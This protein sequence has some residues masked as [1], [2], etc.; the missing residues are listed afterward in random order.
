MPTELDHALKRPLRVPQ[1]LRRVL[2]VEDDSAIRALLAD[3]LQD[4]GYAVAEAVDG[5]HALE[6]LQY[7]RPDLIVLD[8]MLPGMSGWQ[9]LDRSRRQLE[10][11][12]IPVV[13]LSAIKGGGDYPT[14][15]G[16]AAW[17]TKPLDV[18]RFLGAVQRLAGPPQAVPQIPS[19]SAPRAA[20]FP[21]QILIIEDEAP[22]QD[23]LTEQLECEGFAVEV[24]STIE[25]AWRR[26]GED[27]PDLILLDLMLPGQSGWDFLRK[28]RSD[29]EL[30]R[31]P[32][33]VIS[34][35]PKDRLIEAKELG[36][37][38]FLSKPFD[39]DVLTVLAQ[40]VMP[41]R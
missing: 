30:Q 24:A 5:F 29:P 40:T 6:H 38:G 41:V 22:L 2:I 17:Y 4:A 33:L 23:L 15:L 10:E 8:L 12:N 36:A 9:F 35:A 18:D 16:V 27:R 3:L 14:S 32:V 34:A 7:E 39:V 19:R 37:D 1:R 20:P 28:R 11:A 21:R 26:I 13:V 31:I 25:A